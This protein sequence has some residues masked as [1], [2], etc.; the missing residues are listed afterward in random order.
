ME[1]AKLHGRFSLVLPAVKLLL[2]MSYSPALGGSKREGKLIITGKIGPE[3]E[4][5]A[6]YV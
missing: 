4:I 2:G 1:S 3:P 6:K 5:L